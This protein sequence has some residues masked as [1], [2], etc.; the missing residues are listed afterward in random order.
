MIQL[1]IPFAFTQIIALNYC[2]TS[3]VL[4][5]FY[6]DKYELPSIAKKEG[7]CYSYLVECKNEEFFCEVMKLIAKNFDILI[8]DS[9]G[10]L[11]TTDGLN[12]DTIFLG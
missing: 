5:T 11:H 4:G 9:D 12:P 10:Q 6:F 3:E 8:C 7:Y 1:K 2:S